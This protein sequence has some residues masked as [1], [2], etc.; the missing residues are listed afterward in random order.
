VE[1]VGIGRVLGT[2][3]LRG[4]LKVQPEARDTS[5]FA[6]LKRVYVE[7]LE[8]EGSAFEVV[9][10]W[11]HKGA[12]VLELR[13]VES[14]EAAERLRG[15]RLFVPEAEAVA[16]EP[17]EYFV[18]ELIGL[19]VVTDRGREAGVLEEVLEGPANDIYVV[20][21]G[22]GELL[23]PAIGSMVL[24]VDRGEG[25]MLIHDLPGLLEPDAPL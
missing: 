3:G 25:R 7:G 1:L 18:H 2:R 11:E 21:G 17:N 4:E 8:E 12:V 22:Y 13:G 24:E 10:A 23:V 5:R 16:L 19:R 20:R 15:R 9:H 6:R 14:V